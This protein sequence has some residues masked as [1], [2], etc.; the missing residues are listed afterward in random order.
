[1]NYLYGAISY[2]SPTS[3]Q[4]KIDSDDNEKTHPVQNKEI[5]SICL[6]D[7]PKKNPLN[8]FD[9]ILKK[10]HPAYLH[11]TV[12]DNYDGK[13]YTYF[14]E[15]HPFPNW[16][17]D[18]DYDYLKYYLPESITD[19]DNP[20]SIHNRYI[21]TFTPKSESDFDDLLRFL[22]ISLHLGFIKIIIHKCDFS[23]IMNSDKSDNNRVI[24]SNPKINQRI[25][26]ILSIIKK[27]KKG[28]IEIEGFLIK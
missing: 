20:I 3:G 2:F 4:K 15:K 19:I 21:K 6:T 12:I 22:L 24:T 27:K 25:A 9:S 28:Y 23:G 11:R 8:S 7:F 14:S 13:Q 5:G 16:D 26:I 17:T 1:M 18:F 10:H